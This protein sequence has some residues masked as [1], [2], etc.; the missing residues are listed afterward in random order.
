[1]TSEVKGR[2]IRAR[3]GLTN[4]PDGDLGH[5]LVNSVNGLTTHATIF[6][7]PPID[8]TTYAARRGNPDVRGARA[9][10]RGKLQRRL[11]DVSAIRIRAGCDH[12]DASAAAGATFVYLCGSRRRDR[13]NEASDSSCS[14]RPALQRA[15]R[16]RSSRRSD[17]HGLDG[18]DN[19]EHE[20]RDRR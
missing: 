19:H 1:M 20:I 7:K 10:R 13:S 11:G 2:K 9:L 5:I 8:P 12:E 16:R 14:Q 6:S 4:V 15:V 18:T 3:Y 17:P